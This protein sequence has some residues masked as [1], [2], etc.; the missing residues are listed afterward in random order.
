M[1]LKER[2]TR[3][4]VMTISSRLQGKATRSRCAEFVG[5]GA[6]YT[7]N[8]IEI[9]IKLKTHHKNDILSYITT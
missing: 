1:S 6:V 7:L 2:N 8:R 5:F 3:P 9:Q 4:Y